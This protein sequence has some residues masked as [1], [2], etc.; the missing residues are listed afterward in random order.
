MGIYNKDH[1]FLEGVS[2]IDKQ[3]LKIIKN[4]TLDLEVSKCSVGYWEKAICM[5][6]K[7]WR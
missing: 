6:Y 3:F 2:E 1:G 5:G 4:M 7:V